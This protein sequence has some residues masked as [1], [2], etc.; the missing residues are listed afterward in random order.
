MSE[1]MSAKKWVVCFLCLIAFLILP[2]A[3][4]S[5][6]REGISFSNTPSEATGISAKRISDVL[7]K[8]SGQQT[9][10]EEPTEPNSVE[11]DEPTAEKETQ[12]PAST[13]ELL[14]SGQGPNEVSKELVQ[15]GYDIFRGSVST[16]APVT[17]VPV[18]ADYVVGPGDNF[19]I[20]LWGRTSVQYSVTI[21]RNGEIVLP[22]VG[23]LNVAGMQMVQLQSY[24]EDQFSRKHTDFKMAVTMGR[25]RT[26]TVFV[27]GEV[28]APGSYTLSSLSTV[29]NALFAAGG[30]S[31]NGTLRK[32]RLNRGTEKGVTLDLYDFLLGG[33]KSK[34]V[35]LQN[36]DTIFVPL[37][38]PVVGVA[39]NVKRPAIYEMTEPMA[40]ADVLGLAGGVTYAGWLQRVQVERVENHEKRIVVDFDISGDTDIEQ[41]KQIQGTGIYDGDVIKVFPI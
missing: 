23:V 36:G 28:K 35:R 38:G 9:M 10:P 11:L 26:V 6:A 1:R 41:H 37:I 2:L 25:L 33:D 34:D 31:K 29:I 19:T 22:E 32:I 8:Q 14:L 39:G 16:F 40:L 5:L 13:I 4:D 12:E 17:N 15:F 20:T 21:N 27:V 18:G 30:P 7:R 3:G 24:L